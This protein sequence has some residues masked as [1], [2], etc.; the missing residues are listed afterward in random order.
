[1][2]RARPAAGAAFLVLL[3][4]WT[5]K[6]LEPHPVPDDLRRELASLW[7]LLPYVL[8]KCLHAG[9][10]ATLAV[11]AGMWRPTR[12]GKRVLLGF[13]LLHGVGTEIGQTY[14]PNRTGKVT[15]VVIDW[16]GVTAGVLVGW[17]W[18]RP[19]FRVTGTPQSREAGAV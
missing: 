16:C 3:G 1:M 5:W 12:L 13:L 4:L 2:T 17:R 19:A 8:A 15:D 18:W 7:E 10:Y 14:V 9:G 6:L 11:L